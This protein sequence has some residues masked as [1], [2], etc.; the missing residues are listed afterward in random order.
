MDEAGILNNYSEV[1]TCTYKGERYS[2]RNN[3]A[4]Y[5]HARE[6][7]RVRKDDNKWTFGKPNKRTGYMDFCSERVHR[8]VAFAFLGEP[9][10]LQYV[11]DHIDTNRRNNRPQNLR[12]LT[13]LDNV[14]K[15]PITLKKIEYLCGSID[16]F[17]N[18]PSIIGEFANSDPNFE[19]MRTV[20]PEEAKASYERLCE[21]AKCDSEKSSGGRIGEWVYQEKKVRHSYFMTDSK[22]DNTFDNERVELNIDVRKDLL[23]EALTLDALQRNWVTPTEFPC[24]PKANVAN[25]MM[26]YYSN[27]SIGNKFSCNQY[28]DSIILDFAFLEKEQKLFVLCR[29]DESLKP[30]SLASVTYENEKFVHTSYG[31]FFSEDGAKKDFTLVQ[32]KEWTGGVTFD[33]LCN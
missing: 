17:L 4:I 1:K 16:A 20:T 33:D 25:P 32:G 13:K 18:D 14:L 9:P 21:W 24:C 29:N 8:I 12:W 15:N 30:W 22:I 28:G 27:L 3:G 31:M 26:A 10:T 23:V 6:G 2:V 7:K 11:V 19:W 5:R